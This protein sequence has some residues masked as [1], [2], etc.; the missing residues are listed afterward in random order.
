[1]RAHFVLAAL[2]LAACSSPVPLRCEPGAT[3]FH[4]RDDGEPR[5]GIDPERENS[6]LEDWPTSA[7]GFERA[8]FD[9][10]GTTYGALEATP[11]GCSTDIDEF[12]ALTFG[13]PGAPSFSTVRVRFDRTGELD[14]PA[15]RLRVGDREA[16]G[17]SARLPLTFTHVL[18]NGDILLM[19]VDAGDDPCSTGGPGSGYRV[20]VEGF[21]ETTPVELGALSADTPLN[22]AVSPEASAPRLFRFDVAASGTPVSLCMYAGDRDLDPAFP[23]VDSEG[24]ARP[25]TYDEWI[26][27][28][29]TARWL[30][31]SASMIGQLEGYR[32]ELY[33]GDTCGE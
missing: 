15:P 27:Q 14:N 29:G 12:A 13:N 21:E 18:L 4:V 33:E 1:M 6:E 22:V 7:S 26:A 19:S 3:H 2:T 25:G 16:D 9:V 32:I 17:V 11:E 30:D 20:S 23:I 24:I 5:C 28:P 8:Q 10:P 31:V